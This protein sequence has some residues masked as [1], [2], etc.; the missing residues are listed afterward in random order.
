MR[1]H[2]KIKI[3]TIL[4]VTVVGWGSVLG[5]RYAS[6]YW[7]AGAIEEIVTR[8]AFRWRDRNEDAAKNL[9]EHELIESGY[10]YI[11]PFNPNSP[12]NSQCTFS[13]ISPNE[14]HIECWWWDQVKMPL[15]DNYRD[16]EYSIHLYLDEND[17]LWEWEE[18]E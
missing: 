11:L 17:T 3:S 7:R 6:T 14:K 1:R 5:S 4:L 16:I 10:D 13:T 15:V 12:V 8:T 9:L 2:G 18:G